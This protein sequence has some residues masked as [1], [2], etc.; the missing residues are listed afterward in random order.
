MR[1]IKNTIPIINEPYFRMPTN[2]ISDKLWSL[3]VPINLDT[4]SELSI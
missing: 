2:N 4:F 1:E 3:A